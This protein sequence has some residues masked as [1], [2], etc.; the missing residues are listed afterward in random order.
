MTKDVAIH[1]Y[2]NG[3]MKSYP[4][5]S[6]P[7]DATFPWLTYE[8]VTGAWNDVPVSVTVNMWF[9]TDSEVIPNQKADEFRRYIETN[10]IITCDDGRIWVK[11]GEP[12]CQSVKEESD[13]AIKRRYINITLEYWTR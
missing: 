10:D 11:T 8:L 4:V 2:F 1:S 5:T 9:R 13:D 7:K 3:F 6:V 12:W